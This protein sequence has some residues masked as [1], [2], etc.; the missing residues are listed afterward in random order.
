MPPDS[1]LLI[2]VREELF[3]GYTALKEAILQH[4]GA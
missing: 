1:P 2:Q 3:A 4:R